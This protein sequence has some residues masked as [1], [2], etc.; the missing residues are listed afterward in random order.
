MVAGI[1]RH[2]QALLSDAIASGLAVE[3]SNTCSTACCASLKPTIG[4]GVGSGDRL[5]F[6]AGTVSVTVT[7]TVS[8]VRT[9]FVV[10]LY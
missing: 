6:I 8:V 5:A 4:A 9:I 7:T 10:V 3:L 1:S 2:R